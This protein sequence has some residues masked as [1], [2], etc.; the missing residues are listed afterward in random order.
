MC[1]GP[2]VC[3]AMEAKLW[4]GRPCSCSHSLD[5]DEIAVTA[6]SQQRI[7]DVVKIHG[8]LVY[9]KQ[10]YSVYLSL[11]PKSKSQNQS[12]ASPPNHISVSTSL[13]PKFGIVVSKTFNHLKR[14]FQKSEVSRTAEY[15]TPSWV[16]ILG[17]PQSEAWTRDPP[18]PPDPPWVW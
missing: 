10:Y 12:P 8:I 17:K 18:D 16:R 9:C 2:S 3:L 7:V 13:K 5:C 1:T 4:Q 14:S 15:D 11:I 6:C